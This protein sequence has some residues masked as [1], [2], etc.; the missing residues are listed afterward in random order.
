MP[1]RHVNPNQ[2]KLF[3]GG[4]EM[5]A[6]SVASVDSEAM[7]GERGWNPMW[8]RKL[9]E[10][11]QPLNPMLRPIYQPHGAGVYESMEKHGYQAS[12]EAGEWDRPT[13]WVSKSRTPEPVLR[14][15]EGHHRIAAAAD[16]ERRTGRNIWLPV[17][18]E[19]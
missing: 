4:Q 11:K 8:D 13:L 10:A 15:G 17:N 9:R 14:Q 7:K 12:D 2:F 6:A 19:G 3:M 5:K 1:S 16:I 18:Y